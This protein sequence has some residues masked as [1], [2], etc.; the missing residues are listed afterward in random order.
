MRQDDRQPFV[1]ALERARFRA[2]PRG[3][4]VDQESLMTASEI[5][6][7]AERAG[8]TRDC[9]VL[10]VCCGMAGPGRL[11]VAQTGCGYLGLDYSQSALDLAV[12][13]ADEAGLKCRF[14]C[15][16]V[17][18]FPPDCSAEVVML[19]E[20][21]LAF[22]DKPGLLREI[23]R[24]LPMGGRL[25]LT[26]E[27]GQP[28]TPQESLEMPDS[29]TVWL[30]PLTEMESMLEQAGLRVRWR[31]DRSQSHLEVVCS[32]IEAFREDS[33]RISSQIGGTALDELLAAHRLWADWLNR[34][35]VRKFALVGEKV[36]PAR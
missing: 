36:A 29:D 2:F 1:E 22:E 28:L 8:V 13:R 31:E 4:F 3:E 18:P 15:H 25:A 5:L 21:M 10:D 9:Q 33:L 16:H 14:E 17:P 7:L 12:R 19:L 34:G 35:R 32:L 11:L 23:S 26:F 27:E 30:T 20:T 6:L 24:V